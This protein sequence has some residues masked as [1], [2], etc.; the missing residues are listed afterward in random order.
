MAPST[1]RIAGAILCSVTALA[2]TLPGLASAAPATDPV[3]HDFT[4]LAREDGTMMPS[5]SA[6]GRYVVY[7]AEQ[8]FSAPGDTNGFSDVFLRDRLTGALSV[9]SKP[10]SGQS[11]GDSSFG[12][13]SADG[14]WVAFHSNA[15]NLVDGDTN[16][17][18][19]VFRKDLRTGAVA[20][21]S[22]T[23]DGQPANGP[24]YNP[25]V[26]DDGRYVAFHSLATNLSPLDT[27]PIADL[28]LK[29]LQ[30][31]EV[32][33]ITKGVNGG[34][35]NGRSFVPEISGDGRYVAF[36]SEA[37]NL[38]S[39]ETHGFDDTN[40]KWDIFLWDR[41]TDTIERISV[42][43]ALGN[44]DNNSFRPR[45]SGDGRYV[46]FES[47]ASNIVF[48]DTNDV[49]DVFVYDRQLQQMDRASVPNAGVALD[50]NGRSAGVSVSDDGKKVVFQS[51]AGNL[52]AGDTNG[53]ADVFLFD[54]DTKVVERISVGEGGEGNG[55]SLFPAISGDGSVVVFETIASNLESGDDDGY[56]DAFAYDTTTRTL[57]PAS[58][59]GAP[60]DPATAF[61][62]GPYD[63]V[64]FADVPGGAYYETG[65]GFLAANGITKGTSPTT[66]SPDQIVTRGQMATFLF[67]LT[68]SQWTLD[69]EPFTDVYGG[70]YFYEPVKW[71]YKSG[72]TTGTSPTTFS[73][74]D[75]VTR[76]QM[77]VFLWRL[78]GKPA[79]TAPHGF[80][81][82]PDGRF[83]TQA[84][85]WLKTTGI[86]TGTT[87]TTFSPDDP[88]T[89]G[90]MAAFL[91]RL[92][93]RA[94]WT[95]RWVPRG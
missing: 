67:R 79:V 52:V 50:S 88:V 28:Y 20:L 33:L 24:S 65:V 42:N 39:K 63:A 13:I 73:P 54:M 59:L 55:D 45:I 87:P 17:T 94:G 35:G 74:D 12:D 77:A 56:W 36:E 3:R 5:I 34:S 48:G 62:M 58:V 61:D 6:D 78:A 60:D 37:S 15:T 19:D 14:R 85:R 8:S 92:V 53:V 38:I 9:V 23:S 7:H 91:H 66:Y 11:N 75:P 83:Y 1:T 27:D 44:A 40:D 10:P 32:T 29:D 18:W 49:A 2:G 46:A 90:Q 69:P 64:P 76:G 68:G 84:V 71:A 93:T 4:L 80:S 22:T 47:F 70:R 51:W 43:F 86:T 89:R 25:A 82:V 30:T 57:A 16:G 26:S 81:D 95:P 31:G 21:V 72:I 41:D